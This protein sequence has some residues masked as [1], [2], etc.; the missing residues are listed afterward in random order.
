MA[1]V[2]RIAPAPAD[3]P[4]P[5]CSPAPRPAGL[6]W[7]TCARP[8]AARIACPWLIA[9]FIDA[10][11]EFRFLPAGAVLAEARLTGGI[12]FDVPGAELHRDSARSCFDA[13]LAKY[14]IDD[15][16]LHLL[17]AIVRG[18][19]AGRAD[20]ALQSAGLL[21]ISYG[22]A[23]RC[24]SDHELQRQG[25]LVYDALYAWCRKAPPGPDFAVRAADLRNTTGWRQSLRRCR[26]RRHTARIL[27]ALNDATLREIRMERSDPQRDSQ[28]H[29]DQGRFA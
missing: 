14:R 9:R 6:R 2:I 28:S 19:H 15:P 25:F 3:A 18:A 8:R 21:A 16:A 12:P 13:F 24:V 29:N 23:Q 10:A 1:V 17:A 4:Q 11:P 20:L 7:I 22:L 27:T 26:A 5:G